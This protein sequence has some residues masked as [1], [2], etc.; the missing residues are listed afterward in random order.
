[1]PF[2]VHPYPPF[3]LPLALLNIVCVLALSLP[4]LV[5]AET[6][7]I[8]SEATYSM[9]DGETPS[10]AEAMVLQKAKQAALEQAGTYVESYTHVRN[11]DLTVDE[12]KTIAGGMLETEVIERKR[13]LEGDVVRFYV[14]IRA[15]I[16]TDKM[17][18]LAR[19]IKGGNV[20]EENTKVLE[21]YARI[22]KDLEV[23]KRQAAETKTESTREVVLDKIREVEKQFRQVR[24]TETAL[25]KRLLSGEEL[26]AKVE[27][28]LQEE[29]KRREGERAR[30]ERQNRAFDHLLKTI[31]DNGHTIEIGPP[32]IEVTLDRSETVM[33]RFLV[34]ATVTEE[35]KTA[36]REL[37]NASIDELA[38]N[39]YRN[40]DELLDTLTLVLTVTLKGGNQYTKRQR[41]FHNYRSPRSYDLKLMVK[42]TSR[43]DYF[44]VEVPRR[45]V[46][47]IVSI[48]GHIAP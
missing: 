14:K 3:R 2:R 4:P 40:I 38:E 37:Q 32:E 25:Y 13:G 23:L 36:I 1:M 5:Q 47:E 44:G 12:I 20:V 15:R 41:G 26:S 6:K 11:L 39:Q 21:A 45:L 18:D 28:A 8:V 42:Q 19:R 17:E 43:A 33:L 35:A 27:R 46:G 24:S 30:Q 7:T 48:E 16:T 31:R 29:Q 10:F 34:T 22:D 9:G